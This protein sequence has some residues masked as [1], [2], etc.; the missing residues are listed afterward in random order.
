M[1]QILI[2][3]MFSCSFLSCS[4][5]VGTSKIKKDNSVNDSLKDTSTITKKNRAMVIYGYTVTPKVIKDCDNIMQNQKELFDFVNSN[6]RY[7]KL[8]TIRTAALKRSDLYKTFLTQTGFLNYMEN[9]FDKK[10]STFRLSFRNIKGYGPCYIGMYHFP[11][12]PNSAQLRSTVIINTDKKEMS[13]WNFD[14]L[15][16][17]SHGIRCDFR[18]KGSHTI[19]DVVYSERCQA[20]IPFNSKLTY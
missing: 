3:C 2:L 11:S 7:F 10:Y 17:T 5:E 4:S 9:Q 14:N 15:E 13:I 20:F 16:I 19:R 18:I 12:A 6:V 1:K 8:D